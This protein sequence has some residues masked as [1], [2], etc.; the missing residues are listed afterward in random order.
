M[1]TTLGPAFGGATF[2]NG[3]RY[4]LSGFVKTKELDG[5]ARIGIRL[6]RTGIGDVFD[7]ETY[8]THHSADSATGSSDWTA[9][10]VT[11]P[12]IDPAPDRVHLLLEI[13]GV[14][15]CWFDDVIFQQNV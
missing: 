1:A 11:T 7:L 6:H 13:D 15:T 3:R 4:R 9:I 12:V 10:S 2:E 5:R 14:G 8:E